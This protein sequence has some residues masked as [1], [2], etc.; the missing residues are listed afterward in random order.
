MGELGGRGAVWV[1]EIQ[2]FGYRVSFCPFVEKDPKGILWSL[3]K[4]FFEQRQG[5]SLVEILLFVTIHY[6]MVYN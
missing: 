6:V 5:Q 4:T 1:F 3:L 2:M